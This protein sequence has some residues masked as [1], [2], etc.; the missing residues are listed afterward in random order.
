M[1]RKFILGLAFLMAHT[2]LLFSQEQGLCGASEV[3]RQL[4]L[5]DPS[6][7]K[8]IEDFDNELSRRIKSGKMHRT[9]TTQE[10]E[11]PVVVH[12]IT[13]GGALG[14]SNNP[15]DAQ[16]ISWVNNLNRFNAGDTTLPLVLPAGSAVIP[17]KYT[18]AK[19]APDCT[20]TNGIVR[21]DASSNPAYVAY[22]NDDTNGASTATINS[23]S[24]WDPV[25]YLN[26]YLVHK[27]SGGK[28]GWATYAGTAPAQDNVFMTLSDVVNG[29]VYVFSH[30]LGHS[31]G[32]DHTWE[33]HSSACTSVSI[34]SD[35]TTQGDKVCDTEVSSA[36]TTNPCITN[37]DINPCTGVN[38]QGVQ[39]NIMNYH[40]WSCTYTSNKK[41]TQGQ[42]DRAVAKVLEFRQS[43]L[44]SKGATAPDP[45]ITLTSACIPP[46]ATNPG[47][48]AGVG[49]QNVKFGSID[50]TT[51][52]RSSANGYNDYTMLFC[53]TKLIH[54]DLTAGSSTPLNVKF[55][56]GFLTGNKVRVYIDYNNNGVF[57]TATETVLSSNA[58]NYYSVVTA[59]I[60]PPASAVLPNTPYVRMRVIGDLGNA[61]NAA[62][63]PCNARYNGEVEDYMVRIL[64]AVTLSTADTTKDK[65]AIDIYPNPVA[66]KLTVSAPKNTIQKIEII[67]VSGRLIK[68]VSSKNS[69]EVIDTSFLSQG[70]YVLRISTDK[71]VF[72]RNVI[73]R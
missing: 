21:Y 49:V 41:F 51:G 5:K 35:C 30:E 38:Y 3:N 37:S 70:N 44:N 57:D 53:K 25:N 66:D 71:G 67:D 32:L 42:S 14:T 2:N 23:W 43:L 56:N 69:E 48:G 60:I 20:A 46:D 54:T 7:K 65:E 11:I 26:L 12:V 63:A 4:M 17:V 40:G 55:N 24:R 73:K 31:M 52:G 28:S 9:I 10:Y 58:V 45:N 8:R 72:Y 64:P 22:G 47:T 61:S 15:S 68:T 29:N 1:N 19:R 62:M 39:Y 6:F 34:E 50:Y 13:P 27:M 59:N 36:S 33:G 16:I 18:L